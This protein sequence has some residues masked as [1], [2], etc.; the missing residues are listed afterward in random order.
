MHTL[1]QD[2]PTLLKNLC[3]FH[4]GLHRIIQTQIVVRIFNTVVNLPISIPLER[5][6]KLATSAEAIEIYQQLK[7]LS[8]YSIIFSIAF[9]VNI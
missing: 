3:L 8:V 6:L 5:H 9:V 4:F 7:Y 1:T 2:N